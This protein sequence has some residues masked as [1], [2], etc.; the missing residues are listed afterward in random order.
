MDNYTKRDMTR[1]EREFY[2]IGEKISL[3][4]LLCILLVYPL[5]F[6]NGY[7]DILQAKFDFYWISSLIYVAVTAIFVILYFFTL[8]REVRNKLLSSLFLRTEGEKK[9]PFLMTDALFLL[10]VL[11]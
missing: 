11:V 7:Y 5:Y 8:K 3:L 9:K 1:G 6:K 10:L 4:Y 2:G